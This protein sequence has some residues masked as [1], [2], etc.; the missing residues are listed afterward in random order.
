[1]SFPKLLKFE[2]LTLKRKRLVEKFYST[3]S[4][5]FHT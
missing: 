5:Y 3:R 1:M 4:T 2:T